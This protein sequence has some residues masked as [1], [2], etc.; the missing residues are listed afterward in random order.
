M[1]RRP[2]R[3]G[4]DGYDAGVPAVRSPWPHPA[5]RISVTRSAASVPI[6]DS[7]PVPRGVRP[8]ARLVA[9]IAIGRILSPLNSSMIAV[10]LVPIA[11]AFGTSTSAS[12]WLVSGF[13]LAGAVAMP[14]MG[15]I[16]DLFGPKRTFVGGLLVVVTSGVVAAL[17]PSFE[18][19]VLCRIV[20]AFGT[21]TAYPA[22]L[23]IFRTRDP[24]GSAPA[25]ALAFLAIAASALAATGPVLGGI[26]VG[27]VGWEGIFL[28]NIPVVGVGL[29]LALRWLPADP[30]AT[31]DGGL[32]SVAD[33]RS[34]LSAVDA[35]GVG[36]FAAL[37]VALLAFVLTV[38][39]GPEPLL[40][41]VAV[42]SGIL[43]VPR[44]L[45]AATPFIDLRL[46]ARNPGLI[47]LFAE[48]AAVSLVFYGVFY[49]LP[50]WFVG[51]RGFDP[52]AAGALLL[53]LSAM[54]V[55]AASIAAPVVAR[56][57]SG[58]AVI[59]GAVALLLGAL[60][61]LGF[62]DR[63]PIVA[64]MVAAAVLG[65]PTAFTGLGL[66]AALYEATP[67]GMMGTASGQFETFR[68]IGAIAASAVIGLAFSPVPTSAG[69]R[70][71]AIVFVVVSIGLVVA[72]L[73]GPRRAGRRGPVEPPA[74]ERG[75][76]G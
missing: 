55:L 65:I 18:I 2:C 53:P 68:Y 30:P 25:G 33:L 43:L 12:T 66:Q 13:F 5:P 38:P 71:L 16:A 41:V 14:L 10:A 37:I 44:G 23:A 28:V 35:L 45:R 76:A 50:I 73:G 20:M 36:L 34:L 64:I 74:P 22:G 54:G 31:A 69:F 57:G 6:R 75:C 24:H 72:S 27:T 15:R 4:P 49:G 7:R 26:L 8:G 17:A 47:W 42:A 39:S 59:I 62:D 11:T 40:L 56:R 3:R 29:V 58:V 48:Y 51:V 21:S 52:A 19:V 1:E 60:L 63:T 32:R 9:T 70:N 67:A 61:L 46:L